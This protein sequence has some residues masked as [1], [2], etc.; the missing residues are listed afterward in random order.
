MLVDEG[1]VEV[2]DED[3]VGDVRV[4]ELDDDATVLLVPVVEP[5]EVV[6]FVDKIDVVPPPEVLAEAR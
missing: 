3:V 4:N 5:A 2:G 6:E 1:A